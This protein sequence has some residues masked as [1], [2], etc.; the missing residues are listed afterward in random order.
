MFSGK[1]EI[2]SVDYDRTLRGLF[3]VLL[4]NKESDKLPMVIRKVLNKM[5]GD[6]LPVLLKLIGNM[7]ETE[8]ETLLLW[9]LDNY[10][11]QIINWLM[12]LL[13]DNNL[14]DAVRFEEINL[15]KTEGIVG[16]TLEALDVRLDYDA[17]KRYTQWSLLGLLKYVEKPIGRFAFNSQLINGIPVGFLSD[18]LQKKGLY[19][20]IRDIVLVQNKWD[21][22]LHAPDIA[23]MEINDG[24]TGLKLP[25]AIEDILIDTVVNYLK[26]TVTA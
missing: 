16:F 5:D 2:E 15:V 25:E 19:L 8:K 6:L 9:A 23:S 11:E 17:L 1:V 3:P 22:R 26:D 10:K 12:Q 14:G 18:F 7:S 24:Q 4:E 20:K 13:R 21:A